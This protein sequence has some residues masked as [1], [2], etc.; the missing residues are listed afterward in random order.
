MKLKEKVA[1]V[2]G[3]GSG[4]GNTIAL[5]FAKEGAGIAV[6]DINLSAAEKTTEEINQSGGKAI[7][8]GGA[9]LADLEKIDITTIDPRRWF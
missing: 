8:W 2:T 4:I 5:L 9:A 7:A 1:L 6:N 3:A